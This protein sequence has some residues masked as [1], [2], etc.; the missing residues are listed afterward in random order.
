MFGLAVL[1]RADIDPRLIAPALSLYLLLLF[2][3]LTLFLLTSFV[4]VRTMRRVQQNI[5][6]R[7]SAPT[8]SEDAWAMYRLPEEFED[9]RP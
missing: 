4:L 9:D 1:A 3:L 5:W 6:R 7:A 2:L 8:A